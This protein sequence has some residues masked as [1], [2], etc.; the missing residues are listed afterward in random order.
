M[1]DTSQRVGL[2]GC[3]TGAGQEGS[4]IRFVPIRNSPN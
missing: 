4:G 2:Q 1:F 3:D